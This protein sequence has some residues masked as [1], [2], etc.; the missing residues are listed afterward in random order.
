MHRKDLQTIT[1]S[2]TEPIERE[3]RSPQ[4]PIRICH[5]SVRSSDEAFEEDKCCNSCQGCSNLS[6]CNPA[7]H[8]QQPHPCCPRGAHRQDVPLGAGPGAC[9]AATAIPFATRCPSRHQGWTGESIRDTAAVSKHWPCLRA[10]GT[11]LHICT[12]QYFSPPV[13]SLLCWVSVYALFAVC[14]FN[15]SSESWNFF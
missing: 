10:L 5:C 9:K 14:L 2:K 15:T 3:H 4:P 13:F 11:H 6:S 7:W 12:A 8:Q 1:P